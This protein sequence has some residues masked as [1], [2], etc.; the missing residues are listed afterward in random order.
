MLLTLLI[1]I[2]FA[3][4]PAKAVSGGNLTTKSYLY[5]AGLNSTIATVDL[6]QN[7]LTSGSYE[8]TGFGSAESSI[9]ITEDGTLIYTP[10]FANNQVGYITSTDDGKTWS[11]VVPSSN[12]SR[13]QPMFNIHDGRYFYWSSGV[14]GLH[15]SYSDDH[16]ATWKKVGDHV[17][18]AV[19]D[20]AKIISGKP[21]RSQLKNS[22]SILYMSGPS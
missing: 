9:D 5:S 18:P 16:G 2:L 14:P 11:M 6:G 10:A 19:Q 1:G 3:C 7:L 4:R 12:Q 13:I 22:S 21:V 20:W 17:Q 8:Y 15:M